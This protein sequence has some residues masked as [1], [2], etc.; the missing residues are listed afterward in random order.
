MK[1]QSGQTC[2]MPVARADSSWRRDM[3]VVAPDSAP[4]ARMPVARSGCVNPL[5]FIVRKP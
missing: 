2:P 1:H 4:V 5:G 3:P